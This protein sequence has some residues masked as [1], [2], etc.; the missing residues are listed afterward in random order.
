MLPHYTFF[1]PLIGTGESVHVSTNIKGHHCRLTH[2]DI[3]PQDVSLSPAVSNT[4]TQKR[5]GLCRLLGEEVAGFISETPI[6]EI[7]SLNNKL[8]TL[9]HL[10]LCQHHIKQILRSPRVSE[11][12]WIMMKLKEKKKIEGG[13]REMVK[14]GEGSWW[15]QKTGWGWWRERRCKG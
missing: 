12:I 13:E 15:E 8:S 14:E 5:T 1:P 4:H 11:R 7:S 10:P 2:R 6:M 9:F 3:R